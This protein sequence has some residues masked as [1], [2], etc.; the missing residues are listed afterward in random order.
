MNAKRFKITFAKLPLMLAVS[1]SAGAM[2][3][4]PAHAQSNDTQGAMVYPSPPMV[5][6]QRFVPQPDGRKTKLDYSIWSDALD[7]MVLHMGRSIREVPP[8][9]EPGMGTRIVYG[10]DSRLR[11]EGNRIGFSFLDDNIKASFTEYRKDLQ[12]IAQRVDISKL[13]RNEQ[14]AFWTNLHNVAVIEQIALAYPLRQPSQMKIGPEK[15]PLDDAKV[16]TVN[17]VRMSPKDIRTQIVY[18]HWRDPKVIY[19][20]FRGDI[21]GPSIQGEAFTGENVGRMLDRS[22]R[23]FIN[24][25]RGTQKNGSSLD[26]SDIYNEA[27]PYYFAGWPTDLRGHLEEFATGDVREMMAKTKKLNARLYEHDIADF[28]K[29]ERDPNYGAVVAL[30]PDGTQLPESVKVPNNVRRLL[31]ERAVK[32]EKARRAGQRRGIVTWIDI[33]LPEE[34]N[35]QSGNNQSGTNQVDTSQVDTKKDPN[36]VE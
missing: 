12:D 14:L 1:L 30:G 24:S 8:S 29:G 34:T 33:D 5:E 35:R 13:S 9:V 10:H 25:L 23:E 20:F 36:E 16:I 28:S 15:L 22:A 27:R 26:V 11:L 6:F 2:L 21:G 7:L 31:Y 32:T 18:R 17:G 4:M 3:A 19:G